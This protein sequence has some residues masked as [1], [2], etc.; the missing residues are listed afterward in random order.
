[1]DISKNQWK[2]TGG[3]QEFI[4]RTLPAGGDI[5]G[6]IGCPY[7]W[8]YE[9]PKLSVEQFMIGYVF[10]LLGYPFCMAL[11]GSLFSKALGPIPQVSP[12][13]H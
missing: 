8:C 7:D 12:F 13:N 5:S 3:I 10:C 4:T 1:M 2:S 6:L 9:I 11:C